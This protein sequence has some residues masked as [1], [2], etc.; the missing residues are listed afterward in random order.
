MDVRDANRFRGET[1]P[2]D[3]VAGHIPGAMN[4][5][6]TNNLDAEGKFLPAEKLREKYAGVIGQQPAG[7]VIVHCGSGVTACHTLLA[8]AQAGLPMPRLYVGS[9]SEWSRNNLPIATGA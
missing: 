9:W 1:E 5:P 4:V 8:F 2:I 3:T 6:L 7:E